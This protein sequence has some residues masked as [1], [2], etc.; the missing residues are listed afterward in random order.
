LENILQYL[1]IHRKRLK[2]PRTKILKTR[3]NKF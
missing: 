3:K 1:I 2:T